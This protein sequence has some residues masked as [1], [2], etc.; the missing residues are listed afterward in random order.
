MATNAIAS[1]ASFFDIFEIAE[2]VSDV[3][4][5]LCLSKEDMVA[6]LAAAA[7]KNLDVLDEIALVKL[8]SVPIEKLHV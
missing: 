5:F 2:F 3:D 7:G 1:K 6:Y 4:S 8:K